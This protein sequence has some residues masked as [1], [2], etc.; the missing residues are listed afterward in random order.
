MANII[1]EE[2]KQFGTFSYFHLLGLRILSS[3]T[4]RKLITI[5][6]KRSELEKRYDEKSKIL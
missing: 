2:E 4:L 3:L 6:K 1:H 5:E